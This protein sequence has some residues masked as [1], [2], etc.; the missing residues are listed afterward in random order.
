MCPFRN[1]L[2][3]FKWYSTLQLILLQLSCSNRVVATCVTVFSLGVTSGNES[4]KNVQIIILTFKRSEV[5]EIP[6]LSIIQTL[7][8]KERGKVSYALFFRNCN[9]CKRIIGCNCNYSSNHTVEN[10]TCSKN[11]Y[12][13]NRFTHL[14]KQPNNP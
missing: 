3:A 8:A 13:C 2:V 9:Y 11:G 6:Y 4:C 10:V 5:S 1:Y 7:F 12:N 14:D